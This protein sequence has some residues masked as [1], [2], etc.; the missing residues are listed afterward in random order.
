MIL[1]VRARVL[2]ANS[3]KFEIA[4]VYNHSLTFTVFCGNI[5]RLD[6]KFFYIITIEN[7]LDGGNQAQTS[8]TL[9]YLKIIALSNTPRHIL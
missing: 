3:S 4:A 6:W 1:P 5:Q 8:M 7:Q 9:V 2:I